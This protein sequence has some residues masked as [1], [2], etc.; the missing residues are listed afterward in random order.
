MMDVYCSDPNP[1]HWLNP[2]R[3]YLMYFYG[4]GDGRE[5]NITIWSHDTEATVLISLNCLGRFIYIAH[6]TSWCYWLSALV[7]QNDIYLNSECTTAYNTLFN[8]RWP[9]YLINLLGYLLAIQAY[10]PFK[11]AEN[12][13]FLSDWEHGFWP[14]AL[15]LSSAFKI[16]INRIKPI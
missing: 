9:I 3:F 1:C 5:A 6:L 11:R 2:E 10:V 16:N 13:Y 14:V 12:D 4:T 15:S 7:S 8:Q